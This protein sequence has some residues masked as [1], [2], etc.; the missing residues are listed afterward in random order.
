MQSMKRRH[1]LGEAILT[2]MAWE[3]MA[4]K[5]RGAKSILK[6]G[7]AKWV[8]AKPWKEKETAVSKNITTSS[9]WLEQRLLEADKW[10][11]R[12][13]GSQAVKVLYP[14]LTKC[15]Y[16]SWSHRSPLRI[17]S[18]RVS[19]WHLHSR[20]Q[21]GVRREGLTIISEIGRLPQDC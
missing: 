12:R 17:V 9:N 14:A 8:Y 13:R 2:P 21:R 15:V 10:V 5:S 20:V 6:W 11:R 18:R 3:L 16:A 19:G 7:N 4:A 1:V